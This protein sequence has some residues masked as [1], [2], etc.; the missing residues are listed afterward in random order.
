[1]RRPNILIFYTDQQRWDALGANGNPYIHTPNIDRLAA[2][3]TSFTHHFV[4]HPLCMPSRASMLT[5]QYPGTLGITDMG[6][7]VPQDAVTLPRLLKPYGYHTANIGKLHFLNHANRDHRTTHP[8][9]GFDHLEISDEPGVY[10]DAYRAWARHKNPAQLDRL[11]VGLPPATRVW[12]DVMGINDSVRHPHSS[13]IARDDFVGAIPFPADDDLTHSAFVGEQ[14]IEFIQ[15]QDGRQPFLCIAGFY[16]PHAPW[17]VP[18]TYLDRYDP[19]TLPLPDYPPEIDA[20]RPTDPNA[21]FSDAQLR[22]AKHGYYA[23]ITEVDHY[24]GRVLDALE[25]TGLADETI[26]VFTTDHGEWLGDFLRYSKGYPGDDAATRVPLVIAAP[27]AVSGQQHNGIVE[28]VDIVPTLLDLIGVQ[29][30]PHLQG[31][32]LRSQLYGEA[33]QDGVA[34][35]E[36]TGWKGLRTR[37]HRYLIH[38]DGSERLW[39]V[40]TR[41]GDYYDLADDPAHA[42]VLAACRRVLLEKLLNVERPLPRTWPY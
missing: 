8:A 23:M 33:A 37:T 25:A 4:Q 3:G 41:H 5:G 13:D 24:I 7:A 6:V 35:V 28:A 32:S 12:Y 31:V 36:S 27:G 34:L 2:R 16:A 9:Y 11:S 20:Q 14:T 42:P 30:P 22:S 17:V 21:R 1:M 15:R 18:Q 29:I 19:E 26:V 39:D 38:T 10:E 40:T